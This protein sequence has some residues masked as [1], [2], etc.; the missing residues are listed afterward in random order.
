MSEE[1]NLHKITWEAVANAKGHISYDNLYAKFKAECDKLHYDE[2]KY[3]N[4]IARPAIED[5]EKRKATLIEK[6]SARLNAAT[7]PPENYVLYNEFINECNALGLDEKSFNSEIVAKASN[8]IDWS[9]SLI[10]K[11]ITQKKTNLVK[12]KRTYKKQPAQ[13]SLNFVNHNDQ[14][15]RNKWGSKITFI[16]NWLVIF[17]L[18]FFLFIIF[19][20]HFN[21]YIP[22]SFQKSP[23][24]YYILSCCVF[25]L[26]RLFHLPHISHF[27][28]ASQF[29][30][31]T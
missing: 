11:P 14:V 2:Y 7:E 10:P 28:T 29:M 24:D 26:P 18:A 16:W 1:N 8:Q 21:P 9:K 27:R 19:C 5:Y 15:I 13:N 22:K 25:I 31:Y 4:Q 30:R 23:I 12:G 20:K 3:I 6:V 17:I